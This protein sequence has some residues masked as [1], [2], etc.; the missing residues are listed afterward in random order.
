MS[1]A[2]SLK[3]R[4]C[5]AVLRIFLLAVTAFLAATSA[6]AAAPI[7]QTIWIRAAATNRYVS[8]DTNRG[9]FAPLVADRSPVAAFERFQVVDAGG[10]L[11]AFRSVGTGLVVSADLNRGAW[12]PLTADRTRVQAWEQ[13]RWTD[14]SSTT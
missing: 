14:L 6:R 1:N 5:S 4:C 7:G 11:I 10:G 3:N 9:S 2:E 8:A 13:F 12:A